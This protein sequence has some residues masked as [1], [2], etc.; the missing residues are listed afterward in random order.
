MGDN[1]TNISQ[2]LSTDNY[3]VDPLVSKLFHISI[4]IVAICGNGLIC[5]IFIF[6]KLLYKHAS[7]KL[8]LALAIIDGLTGITILIAPDTV[9]KGQV[10]IR[11]GASA[12]IYCALYRSYYFFWS[13]GIMSLY[14]I[15]VL[16][17]ERW[18]MIAKPTKYK[19]VFTKRIVN[20][21]TVCIIVIGFILNSPNMYQRYHYPGKRVW[22]LWRSL[23][24]GVVVNRVIYFTVFTLK[25]LLPIT[26][27]FL[28]Y[29][30]ILLSFH[31]SSK[32]FGN[33]SVNMKEKN[34]R[35]MK[36]LTLMAFTSAFAY[37]VCWAPNQI[38]FTLFN[39]GVV[40]YH[41]ITIYVNT[42]L[43]MVTSSLNP[44]IYLIDNKYYRQQC[45]VLM[46]K[47]LL[48]CRN[49]AFNFRCLPCDKSKPTNYINGL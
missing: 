10:A 48:C 47:F 23:P 5:S 9:L 30:L 13:F 35:M 19:T 14:F 7:S 22:C 40:R 11:P 44:F 4:A 6:N 29:I 34:R 42:I 32:K 18:Y 36:Q 20:I 21:I 39:F 15:A 45:K 37:F 31:K 33:R 24:G 46:K 8:I 49:K 27:T 26:V 17:V 28:C 16:G 2:S 1:A 12:Y 25:F 41:P 3:N 43:V 38:Y